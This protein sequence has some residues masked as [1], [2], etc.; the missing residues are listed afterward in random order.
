MKQPDEIALR[1]LKQTEAKIVL[2]LS[3]VRQ[4][5][6]VLEPSITTTARE[7]PRSK[8]E[9]LRE[10]L[11]HHREGVPV[12]AISELLRTMGYEN[13]SPNFSTNWLSPSQLGPGNQFFTRE[14]GWIK[15]TPEFLAEIDGLSKAVM[16]VKTSEAVVGANAV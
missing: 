5:I 4:A 9:L 14:K 2:Q 1:F 7:R 11:R 6:A 8:I 13:C 3:K 15:P 10:V 12:K 16:E